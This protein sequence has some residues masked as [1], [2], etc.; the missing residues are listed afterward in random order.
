M[1]T[2][3]APIFVEAK[4]HIPEAASNG[5]AATGDSLR[6]IRRS[7]AEAR[8]FY[9][10]RATAAWDGLFYQ[11]ANRLAHH[12]FLRV[13]NR[14]PAH[15]VFLY[16]VNDREMQGPMSEAEWRG[17]SRLIHAALGL[18]A[19]LEKHAVHDVFIDVGSLN[20]SPGA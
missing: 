11:Y 1:T 17:A 12:Y 16:F 2:A 15:L 9:A 7:L 18:P 10:P 14:V 13:V 5:T 19:D 20:V 4:A 3:G 6:K 8:A